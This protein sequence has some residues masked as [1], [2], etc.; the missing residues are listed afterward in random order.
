MR[1]DSTPT[2]FI[3]SLVL[4]ALLIGGLGCGASAEEGAIRF[5]AIERDGVPHAVNEGENVW[6]DS[7][8]APLRF[9]LE[10][11]YGAAEAPEEAV[12][13]SVRALA[14]D[15]DGTV[16]V[17]DAQNHRLVAFNLDGSVRWTAGREGQGPGEFERPRSLVWDG[18]DHLYVVN[19][20]GGRL[21]RWSTDGAY[22][23]GISTE[24]F[25]AMPLSLVG[26]TDNRLVAMQSAMGGQPQRVFTIDTTTWA[27]EERLAIDLELDLP[28]G[29]GMSAPLVLQGK[30]LYAGHVNRYELSRYALA[31][32]LERRI[33]GEV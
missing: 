4:F 17:L 22:V 11:T 7:A 32:G 10:Q 25:D 8:S 29:L 30:R 16:Y 20:S 27:M 24:Q 23:E 26:F 15:D 19:Q 18:G 13:A 33:V 1:C 28:N 12:L 21:D 9:E 2:L 6:S 14:V 3:R 31:E 5:T